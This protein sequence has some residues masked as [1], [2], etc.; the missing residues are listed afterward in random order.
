MLGFDV[1][2]V[3][4]DKLRRGESNIGHIKPDTVRGMLAQKFEPT[5]DFG[6]LKEA[7]AVIICV[8]TPLEP[9]MNSRRG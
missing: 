7:D 6:R 1:D 4:V 8:P 2:P 5:T 3:K 9:V